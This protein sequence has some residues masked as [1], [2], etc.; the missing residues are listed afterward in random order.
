MVF[1]AEKNDYIH[2]HPPPS[3]WKISPVVL[4]DIT[5]MAKS[6]IKVTPKNMQKGIG[7]NYPPI[8]RSIFSSCQHRLGPSHGKEGK[9]RDACTL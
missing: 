8:Y 6:N 7:L 5:N 2:N 1:N 4:Q 3:E 9:K